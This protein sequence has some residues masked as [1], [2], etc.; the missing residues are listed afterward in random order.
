M[1]V[2]DLLN[3]VQEYQ[4]VCIYPSD[5]LE[6]NADNPYTLDGLKV[7]DLTWCFVRVIRDRTVVSI[8]S[9]TMENGNEYNSTYLKIEYR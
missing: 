3:M 5:D 8:G 6:W 1:K 9:D 4:R 2:L 7:R